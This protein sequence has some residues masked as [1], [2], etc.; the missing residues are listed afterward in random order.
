M[1][2]SYTILWKKSE[3]QRFKEEWHE[4]KK[5]L[6]IVNTLVNAFVIGLFIGSIPLAFAYADLVRGYN[7]TGGELMIPVLGFLVLCVNNA[8]FEAKK[9]TVKRALMKKYKKVNR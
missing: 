2:Y 8:Y 3:E 7:G 5:H 1:N 9:R 6:D 4:E